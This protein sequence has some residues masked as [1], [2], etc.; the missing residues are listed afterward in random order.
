MTKNKHNTK[1]YIIIRHKIIIWEQYDMNSKYF[2]CY[3]FKM[4]QFFCENGL[5]YIVRS[6][7]E[8]TGKHFWIFESSENLSELLEQWRNNKPSK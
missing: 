7:H 1:L 2:Y 5:K 6:V 4:K 3:S 8:K